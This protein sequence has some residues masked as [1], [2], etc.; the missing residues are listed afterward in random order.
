ME[1][2][3]SHENNDTSERPRT[4]AQTGPLLRQYV[5]AHGAN[6]HQLETIR[7]A[8][9]I[10]F[11]HSLRNVREYTWSKQDVRFPHTY[12]NLREVARDIF[13]RKGGVTREINLSV[14]N[15][16]V[17]HD[18]IF[19]SLGIRRLR[20]NPFEW[21]EFSVHE[22][23]KR[24]PAALKDLREG[25]EPPDYQIST[26]GY[27][28]NEFG[29]V[30]PDFQSQLEE[31]G[32]AP[33]RDIY[34][35]FM[36]HEGL[37]HDNTKPM[38]VT[39]NGISLGASVATEVAKQLVDD[40]TVTQEHGNHERPHLVVVM[41]VPAGV[42]SMND[43]MLRQAQMILGFAGEV[44]YH[45]KLNPTFKTG[46][47]AGETAV[48]DIR[49]A[50]ASHLTL[51]MDAEQAELKDKAMRAAMRAILRGVEIPEGLK[52]SKITGVYDPTMY[53]DVRRRALN[54]RT[55]S[56]PNDLSRNMLPRS[57]ENQREFAVRMP[58]LISFYRESEFK[59]FD[60]AAKA[61]D[62]IS[63]ESAA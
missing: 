34:A 8:I 38:S 28:T 36:K 19:S 52:V 15:R 7:E 20:G 59:R 41:Y 25:R 47:S 9:E 53:S 57:D 29:R 1:T 51:R 45:A 56:H 13:A 60:A 62:E 40:G 63:D 33:F 12:V 26:L 42:R 23:L 27:P 48:P 2:P 14:E 31:T 43:W 50:L 58:H 18:F 4:F 54:E 6:E 5:D 21:A 11:E 22:M 32:L 37:V 44:L 3:R 17:E 30:T 49:A 24:L 39:F 61:I 46:G 16:K 55:D 35:E 10:I